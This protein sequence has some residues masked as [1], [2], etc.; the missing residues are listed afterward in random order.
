MKILYDHQAFD[1]QYF[2]GVSNCFVKLIENLPDTCKYDIAL[3]ESDN[4]H[5]K[6]SNLVL[7]FSPRRLNKDVFISRKVFWGRGFLYRTLTNLMPSLTSTGVN[8]KNSISFL[9][10]GDFDIFHPTF[11][12]DYFLPYL[13][14]K[15]YVLTVH[16]MIPE[17]FFRKRDIQLRSKP[18]LIREAAHIIAVSEKT[19]DDLVS[20]MNVPK[21][22]VTVIYHGSS[23][24]YSMLKDNPIVDGDYILYVG[25]RGGYKCWRQMLKCIAPV[26][27][28]HQNLRLV[29]TSQP[30]DN[31]ERSLINQL[32]L[33]GKVIHIHPSDTEMPNLYSNALCFIYPSKYEGFGIPILE[34]Y[35]AYCPVLLNHSSCFPEIAQDAAI[36]FHMDENNS[37]LE[38][39]M[40]QFLSMEEDERKLLI[41][42][43]C[44][45]L[46][47]FSWEQSARKLV[48][49]YSS[50]LS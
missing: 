48:D 40:E 20:I 38:D 37:D 12:D 11:F 7:D 2:G 25:M 49:V 41:E 30:F 16:D 42:K 24:I 39:V 1:M 17:L 22:K 6:S 21:S 26:M 27:G 3:K 5:L 31:A 50:V 35:S 4:F 43:Q 23:G 14:Q 28:R 34:A 32:G 9:K 33:K 47:F 44:Q 18:R 36:Y 15:P 29:C 45:R 13:N 46:K 10:R 8:R 19:K